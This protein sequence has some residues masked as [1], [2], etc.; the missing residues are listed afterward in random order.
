MT[1][2]LVRT[3]TFPFWPES[4]ASMA[5]PVSLV[6]VLLG[7]SGA[8]GSELRAWPRRTRQP[9]PL[10]A[11]ATRAAALQ[12]IV[13]SVPER[14]LGASGPAEERVTR[15]SERFGTWC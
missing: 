14:T 3:R 10:R 4:A 5:L 2:E 1:G 6:P 7:A 13:P 8:A 12:A 15:G 9:A 11:Q